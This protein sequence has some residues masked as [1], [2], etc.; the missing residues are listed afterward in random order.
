[1]IELEY[2]NI[3]LRASYFLSL[4]FLF[5]RYLFPFEFWITYDIHVCFFPYNMFD[6][7]GMKKISRKKKIRN[8]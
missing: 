1:M 7:A 6:T 2:N 4:S 5:R 8:G 3:D